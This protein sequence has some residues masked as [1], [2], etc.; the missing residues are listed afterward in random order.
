[1][2]ISGITWNGP[3]IDDSAL[4]EELPEEL[5]AMLKQANGFILYQGALHI[6][7]L[8]QS[9]EWHSLR[10]AWKSETSFQNLYPDLTPSDIPFAQDPFGDQFLW[11]EGK[12]LRLLAETGDIEFTSPSLAAFF[13]SVEKDIQSFLNVSLKQTIQPGELVLAY[14][15]FCMKESGKGASLR[16]I[17]SRRVILFHADLAEQIRNVPDGGQIEIKVTD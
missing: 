6:R 13:A 4:L 10:S 2:N 15:P 7:G 11:R 16:S 14:P 5:A 17:P 8:C 3:M 1:M 12:I 9:P